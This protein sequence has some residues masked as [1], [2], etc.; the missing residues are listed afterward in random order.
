[1]T[2]KEPDL[3]PDLEWMPLPSFLVDSDRQFLRYND[4]FSRIFPAV[5]T[6]ADVSGVIRDPEFLA[7]VQNVMTNRQP[8]SCEISQ[9]GQTSHYFSVWIK[10]LTPPSDLLIIC[11]QETTK[12]HEAAR[13]RSTFVADVSHE[14]RS[15]LTTMIATLETL[16]GRAGNDLETR[17][18]FI[19]MTA[20]EASR[21][22]HIVDDLLTLS[23]TEARRHIPPVQQVN[24][25]E[26]LENIVK[27][28]SERL[29]KNNIT[30]RVILED[31]L[32]PVRGEWDELFK[33]FQNL[34]DNAINYGD[35]DSVI[36]IQLFA[37]PAGRS[38]NISVNNYGPVISPHHIPRLTERFYR[39]DSSRSRH[40]GGTGLGLAIVKHI[41]SRHK[42]K[43]Q[44]E[45]N[46]Q[47]GT[48]FTVFCPLN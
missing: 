46:P 9:K 43:L 6:G 48:S 35:E 34:L 38:Q 41:L 15:P 21:M 32:P 7:A 19:D 29:I 3:L 33:V 40:L 14:L 37:D 24:L 20:A 13:M 25:K 8:L 28:S 22:R 10:A 44:I 30:I 45:S 27:L 11:L 42:C 17:T 4:A 18:R 5:K 47:D 31:G 2:A 23:A 39:A 16:K 1:M 26:L 12:Q 36:T